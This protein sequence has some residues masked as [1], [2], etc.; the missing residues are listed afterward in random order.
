M[1]VVTADGKTLLAEVESGLE[2]V[3][4]ERLPIEPLK[5]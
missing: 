4:L 1:S 2:I 3:D 5:K